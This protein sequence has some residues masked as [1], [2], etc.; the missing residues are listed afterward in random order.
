MGNHTNQSKNRKYFFKFL[1]H[2]F[3][4]QQLLSLP[5]YLTCHSRFPEFQNIQN[6]L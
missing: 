3:H 6:S 4:M 5:N 2:S 1:T